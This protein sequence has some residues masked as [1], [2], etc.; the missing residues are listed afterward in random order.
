MNECTK[1]MAMDWL[2]FCSQL[3]NDRKTLFALNSLLAERK[4]KLLLGFMF[5]SWPAAVGAMAGI[6]LEFGTRNKSLI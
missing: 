2:S 6:N 5:S 1:G 4:E 3:D